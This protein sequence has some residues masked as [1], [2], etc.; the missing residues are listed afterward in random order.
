M[1]RR[2]AGKKVLEDTAMR[3]VGHFSEYG[4]VSGREECS[5]GA[6][7]A[8]S[9]SSDAS[10]G[11]VTC[12]GGKR[13]WSSCGVARTRRRKAT[14]ERKR[15]DDGGSEKEEEGEEAKDQDGRGG[16]AVLYSAGGSRVDY[17]SGQ[18][19]SNRACELRNPVKGSDPVCQVLQEKAMER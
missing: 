19:S 6:C 9:C 11:R 3:R 12:T 18:S 5:L 2:I 10:F 7:R 8:F 1:A 15:E 14:K 17:L 16:Q 4:S 13:R